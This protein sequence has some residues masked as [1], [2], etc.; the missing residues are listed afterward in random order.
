MLVKL[1]TINEELV[2]F[3]S[4]QTHKKYTLSAI[5]INPLHIVLLKEDLHYVELNVKK[6]LPEGFEKNQKFTRV[7]INR[8]NS[9]EEL[10]VIGDIKGIASLINEGK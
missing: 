1:M 10:I 8:G 3:S 5:Y 2:N 9:G 6:Q 7:I 4:T